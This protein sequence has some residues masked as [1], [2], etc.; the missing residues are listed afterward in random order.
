MTKPTKAE[1]MAEERLERIVKACASYF[2]DKTCVGEF[3]TRGKLDLFIAAE[4][5]AA[6]ERGFKEG[7]KKNRE[8]PCL[9]S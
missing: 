2:V 7:A 4:I 5:Q 8:V 9:L 6:Y 1:V 3:G